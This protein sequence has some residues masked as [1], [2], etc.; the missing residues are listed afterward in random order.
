MPR[1]LSSADLAQ[2]TDDN[3]GIAANDDVI[4]DVLTESSAMVDS[5][6]RLRY[7]VPLQSSEQVKGLTLDIAVYKLF[8]RRRRMPDEVSA[9]YAAAIA[10]LKDVSAGKAGLDQPLNATA[11]SGAGAVL[12]ADKDSAL[13]SELVKVFTDDNLKG[14]A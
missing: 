8:A 14:F 2:L 7:S 3:A 11:Q 6:C 9:A 10:F 4:A 1:R 12:T 13:A 5:Y